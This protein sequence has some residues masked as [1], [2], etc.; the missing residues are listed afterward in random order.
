LAQSPDI[1]MKLS[2]IVPS[3]APEHGGPS[4]SA[5]AV[6]AAT[7]RIGHEV[8]LL[9]LGKPGERRDG[10][11]L[12]VRTFE[13]GWPARLSRSSGLKDH[14][15]TLA[16]DV[17]HHHSLWLRTLAYAHDVARRTG[18]PLVI[19]PKGMM[20]SWA[21]NHHRLRKQIADLV[22][23]PGALR[24]VAGWH[25][26][27]KSEAEGISALGYRQ[28]VCVAPNGIVAPAP[29][30]SARA[31][32][33]WRER[34]PETAERKVALFY[35]RFHAK[36]RLL[37]LIDLWAKVRPKDWVLLVVGIPE[38]HTVEQ[39]SQ[40]AHRVGVADL[41]RVFSGLHVPPPYAVADLF[42]LPSH[43][44]NFGMS[45]AEA[46]AQG[47]PALVTDTTPW[48]DLNDVGGGGCVP[49]EWYTDAL[50]AATAESRETLRAQG[51]RARS[52]VLARYSWETTARTLA[53][54]Y[55]SL[56]P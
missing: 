8:E 38:Q 28:P 10:S 22:I 36:K 19:S 24:R 15:R 54:F 25:A 23:H 32:L 12:T 30:E 20:T 17:V 27:S 1:R 26:T 31:T 48:Q 5:K 14:C 11:G 18:A 40:Y 50:R 42:L 43:S 4:R 9:A 39:V 45:I 49:W 37:E 7:A 47:V 2:V 56:L 13:A 33:F 44:E 41:V 35:S 34:V 3:L 46:L 29:E 55:K 6:A 53:D 21:W 51:A 52:W 16:P